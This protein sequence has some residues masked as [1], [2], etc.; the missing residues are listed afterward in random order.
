MVTRSEEKVREQTDV[1]PAVTT[2]NQ[3]CRLSTSTALLI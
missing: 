2:E 3:L 1:V